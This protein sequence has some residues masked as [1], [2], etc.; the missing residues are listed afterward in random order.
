MEKIRIFF[1]RN[2]FEVI[3]RMSDKFG[4][5][6]S[7]LRLFFIYLCFF[8]LGFAFAFYIVIAFFLW[9]KDSFVKK[10]PSVF[11]L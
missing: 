8:T 4:L 7:T 10:R 1:E 5:H 3:G 9:I 6:A 11:D 2:G